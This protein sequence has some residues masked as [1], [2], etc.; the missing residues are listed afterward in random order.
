MATAQQV[1]TNIPQ[2]LDRL[3]WSRWRSRMVIAWGITWL[4]D[5][6]EVTL[7]VVLQAFCADVRQKQGGTHR[8]GPLVRVS[9]DGFPVSRPDTGLPSL[10]SLI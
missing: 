6:L 8:T 7:A 1:E 3:P 10:A 4:L 9:H 5:R 2:R